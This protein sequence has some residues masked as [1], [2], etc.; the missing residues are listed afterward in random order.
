MPLCT[1]LSVYVIPPA[2]DYV[3]AGGCFCSIDLHVCLHILFLVPNWNVNILL[4][5]SKANKFSQLAYDM[6]VI[7]F[8][9]D[10]SLC[11]R[12]SFCRMNVIQKQFSSYF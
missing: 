2:P 10:L 9:L 3:V 8:H 5:D 6:L 12:T 1:D 4:I 7:L 11:A